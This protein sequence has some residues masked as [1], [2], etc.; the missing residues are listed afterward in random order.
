M[1]MTKSEIN[2]RYYEKNKEKKNEQ[3]DR[4]WET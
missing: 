4:D 1:A 2:K 3:P